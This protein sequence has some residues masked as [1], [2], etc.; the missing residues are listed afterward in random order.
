MLWWREHCLDERALKVYN[1]DA[2]SP[3]WLTLFRR[4]LLV[5]FTSLKIFDFFT[6]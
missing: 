3:K 2:L 4:A 5:F 1:Y 6:I